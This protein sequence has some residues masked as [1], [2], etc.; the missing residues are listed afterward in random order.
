MKQ[1]MNAESPATSMQLLADFNQLSKEKF[2]KNNVWYVV[3]IHEADG[4]DFDGIFITNSPNTLDEFA[5]AV[6]PLV[7]TCSRY[8]SE[9]EAR[10]FFFEICDS[11]IN[12]DPRNHV[13]YLLSACS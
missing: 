12:I 13:E 2:M 1:A 8:R 6:D 9:Q 10:D 7:V 11:F 3:T 5:R 4:H